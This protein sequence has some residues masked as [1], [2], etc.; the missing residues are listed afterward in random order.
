LWK[1]PAKGGINWFAKNLNI[2]KKWFY[3]VQSYPV[4]PFLSCYH[5]KKKDVNF[6]P[7]NGYVLS[8]TKSDIIVNLNFSQEEK[9]I[10]T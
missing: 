2:T 9:C 6:Y 8:V 1:S 4:N 7:V 10:K 5:V 3:L